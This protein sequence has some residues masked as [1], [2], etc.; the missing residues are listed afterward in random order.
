MKPDVYWGEEKVTHQRKKIT[1]K[2]GTQQ[3]R[4]TGEKEKNKK[5]ITPEGVL[6]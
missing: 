6:S 1:R 2:N 5:G 3:R 4:E